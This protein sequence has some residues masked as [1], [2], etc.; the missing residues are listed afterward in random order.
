MV[1]ATGSDHEMRRAPAGATEWSSRDFRS[2]GWGSDS[3]LTTNRWFA[4]PANVQCPF[5]THLS[6][7]GTEARDSHVGN[8]TSKGLQRSQF[9][10]TCVRAGLVLLIDCAL[11]SARIKRTLRTG[12]GSSVPTRDLVLFITRFSQ[13]RRGGTG[14]FS[15]E[16]RLPRR[17]LLYH[18]LW[19]SSDSRPM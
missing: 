17:A 3:L 1:Q 7:H 4:P 5:G 19:S 12:D 11:C 6:R 2:P 8:Q 13:S 15:G 9:V 16:K 18:G 10:G 14:L